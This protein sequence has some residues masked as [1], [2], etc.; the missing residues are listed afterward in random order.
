MGLERESAGKVTLIY[1]D[2][3]G[4]ADRCI[5]DLVEDAPRPGEIIVVTDD[6]F[7]IRQTLRAQGHHLGCRDFLRSMRRTAKKAA[8]PLQGEDPRKFSGAMTNYEVEKW[9]EWCG[10][11]E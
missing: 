1:A 6:K 7:I 4:N 11:N 3:R 9:M 10:L 2:P 8:D 5:I